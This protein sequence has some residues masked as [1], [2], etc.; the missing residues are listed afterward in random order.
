MRRKAKSIVAVAVLL[1]VVSAAL[2]ETVDVRLRIRDANAKD[3]VTR[4]NLFNVKQFILAQGLRDT[5]CEMY[6]DNPAFHTANF[7]FFLNPDSVTTRTN[8]APHEPDF[9]SLTIRRQVPGK[10][11][12]YTTVEFSDTSFIYITVPAPA[13]DLT[14]S[15]MRKVVVDAMK[16]ILA[17]MEKKAPEGSIRETMPAPSGGPAP[18]SSRASQISP[19]GKAAAEAAG[20]VAKAGSSWASVVNAL[21]KAG[22]AFISS[23]YSRAEGSGENEGNNRSLNRYRLADG[24]CVQ[25]ALKAR[26]KKWD[27]LGISVGPSGVDLRDESQWAKARENGDLREVERLELK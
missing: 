9:S 2:A 10:G 25:F 11:N 26:G 20:T 27:V 4:A 3:E 17:D 5:Y 21:E 19:G 12:K 6:N 15:D 14:V 16:E 13:D 7:S 18:L 23:T 1:L 24:T 8:A 22:A